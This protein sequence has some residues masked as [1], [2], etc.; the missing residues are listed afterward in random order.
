MHTVEDKDYAILDQLT[1][2]LEAGNR[3]A[4]GGPAVANMADASRTYSLRGSSRALA[5]LRAECKP[6]AMRITGHMTVQEV[7]SD[8]IGRTLR[9]GFSHSTKDMTLAADG[10]FTAQSSSPTWQGPEVYGRWEVESDGC[11]RIRQDVQP[12]ILAIDLPTK[13]V[14]WLFT[15]ICRSRRDQ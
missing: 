10:S 6:P 11:V 3:L 8:I 12:S 15:S 13:T 4:L 9:L 14:E 7:Q 2:A 5:Q 1:G